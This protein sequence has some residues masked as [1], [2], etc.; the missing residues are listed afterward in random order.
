VLDRIEYSKDQL[1]PPESGE[2]GEIEEVS[3]LVEVGINMSD[4]KSEFEEVF[5][6]TN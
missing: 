3:Q 2:C 4:R 6:L 5:G 1:F